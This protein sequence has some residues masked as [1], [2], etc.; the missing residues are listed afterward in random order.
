[1]FQMASSRCRST[2]LAIFSLTRVEQ[3]PLLPVRHYPEKNKQ[4]SI[5]IKSAGNLSWCQRVVFLVLL[6]Q[7]GYYSTVWLLPNWR[8]RRIR[9]PTSWETQTYQMIT[10]YANSRSRMAWKALKR[11][12]TLWSLPFSFFTTQQR[13]AVFAVCKLWLATFRS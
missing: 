1:M 11:W 13:S 7:S 4:T 12:A 8:F 10:F 3:S 6:I 5:Q 9:T 2:H